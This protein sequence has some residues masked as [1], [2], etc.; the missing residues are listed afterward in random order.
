MFQDDMFQKLKEYWGFE[1]IYMKKKIIFRILSGFPQGLALGYSISILI[2][3][4]Y[5]DGSYFPFVPEFIAV[6]GNEI[7]AVML[8]AVLCGVIGSGFSA[9]SVIW[10]VE[11]WGI[12]KQT[13]IYFLLISVIMMPIAYATCWM[14]HSLKGVLSYFGIFFLIFVVIWMVQYLIVRRMVRRWNQKLNQNPR[15]SDA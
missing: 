5:A 2:S 14:E 4:L 11:E 6:M 10:E 13:G 1:V 3:L 8:Q 9:A 12:L 7:N 15:G